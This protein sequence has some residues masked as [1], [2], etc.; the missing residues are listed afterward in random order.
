MR[1]DEKESYEKE[2]E[3]KSPQEIRLKINQ[4][5]EEITVRKRHADRLL[6]HFKGE[7][8]ERLQRLIRNT[9]RG[10]A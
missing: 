7:E 9:L 4:L 5:L 8:K 3:P 1:N 2:M 10:L 6:V